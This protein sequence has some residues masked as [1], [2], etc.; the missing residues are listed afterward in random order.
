MNDSMPG[1]DAITD[2]ELPAEVARFRNILEP[3]RRAV[4]R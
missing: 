3:P 4:C 1:P 2:P